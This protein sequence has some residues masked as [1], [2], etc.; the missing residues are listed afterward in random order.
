MTIPASLSALQNWLDEIKHDGCRLA[1]P[2]ARAR[3]GSG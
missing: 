3:W 1:D 2:P